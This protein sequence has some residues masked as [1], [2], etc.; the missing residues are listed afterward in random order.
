MDTEVYRFWQDFDC[1]RRLQ[2]LWAENKLGIHVDLKSITVKIKGAWFSQ[3][4]LK[5]RT[6]LH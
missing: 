6:I 2:G 1:V 4:G 5:K 3:K